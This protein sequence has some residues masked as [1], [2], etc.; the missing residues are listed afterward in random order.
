MYKELTTVW[1]ANEIAVTHIVQVCLGIIILH[2]QLLQNI[3]SRLLRL[4]LENIATP[5][6]HLIQRC[7]MCRNPQQGKGLGGGEGGE[8]RAVGGRMESR[9][10][11]SDPRPNG[12]NQ[13]EKQTAIICRIPS[14]PVPWA[15]N[16]LVSC[17]FSATFA[18]LLCHGVTHSTQCETHG[19]SKF[20]LYSAEASCTHT[21]SLYFAGEAPRAL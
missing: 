17:H 19:L 20:T 4:I 10:L 21:H 14:S 7:E 3:S 15:K 1:E 8:Q 12:L 6:V 16:T 11:H 13:P 5:A 9:G 2:I 18:E